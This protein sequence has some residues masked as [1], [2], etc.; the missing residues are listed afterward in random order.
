MI[1]AGTYVLEPSVLERVP[2]QLSVSIEHETFPR[3]VEQ[4]ATV[5]ALA[6][7]DYWIDI[8]TPQKYIAAHVDVIGGALG[9]P[10][11]PSAREAGSGIWLESDTTVAPDAVLEEATLVMSGASIDADARVS[12]STLGARA[13][14]GAG[15]V[16][17]RAVLLDGASVATGAHVRESIIGPGACIEQDAKVT[18]YSIVGAGARVQSG[19]TLAAGRVPVVAADG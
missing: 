17:D 9:E 6:S 10:P 7:N 12:G 14:V 1:N 18:D 19:S 16:L 15:A 5:Y 4:D 11:T 13:T 2:P 8:G 3:L